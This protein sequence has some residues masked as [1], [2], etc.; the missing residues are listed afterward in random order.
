MSERSHRPSD[1]SHVR[2]RAVGGRFPLLEPAG[3]DEAQRALYETITESP[4]K[5][6]PFLLVDDD[7]RLAGP[8]NAMLHSPAIGE[9]LQSLGSSLR[10]GG[11][12]PARTRELVICLVA[13]A[14]D[15][16]YE[17]YAHSRVA[18]QVSVTDDELD[19]LRRGE[20]PPSLSSAETATL[21]LATALL[22]GA[23]IDDEVHERALPHLGHAGVTELTVLVGYYQTLAGLLAVGAVPAP[24]QDPE[25]AGTLAD[26]GPSTTP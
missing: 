15:S 18:R 19:G 25:T 21:D 26:P 6:G 7:G 16:D 22:R 13:A 11:R 20:L 17:W 9:A 3:L 4:R 1:R 10:F 12:L 23:R 8:F 14:L 2:E 5:D 24:Q